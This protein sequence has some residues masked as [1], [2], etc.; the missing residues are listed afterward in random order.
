MTWKM[1]DEDVV[2]KCPT[3]LEY[4][5]DENI[6]RF[7]IVLLSR[8]AARTVCIVSRWEASQ[9]V[10][11]IGKYDMLSGLNYFLNDPIFGRPSKSESH[12]LLLHTT[13]SFSGLW[14][15]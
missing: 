14:T 2:Y 10:S 6:N 8:L 15:T 5:L 1:P 12:G 3:T 9:K 13:R 4:E 11:S 7:V